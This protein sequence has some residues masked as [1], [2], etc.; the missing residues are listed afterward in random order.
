[1]PPT[2]YGIGKMALR[3]SQVIDIA[4]H[5]PFNRINLPGKDDYPYIAAR[6]DRAGSVNRPRT[7]AR[8]DTIATEPREVH[9]LDEEVEGESL[10]QEP[11]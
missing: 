4:E 2:T 3:L 10:V 7:S 8:T 5:F 11:A 1:M 9:A 6:P